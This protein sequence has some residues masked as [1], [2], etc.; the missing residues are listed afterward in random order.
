MASSGVRL[1]RGRVWSRRSQSNGRLGVGFVESGGEFHLE[2]C[3]DRLLRTGIA[4]QGLAGDPGGDLQRTS[5]LSQRHFFHIPVAETFEKALHGGVEFLG[6]SPFLLAIFGGASS[7]IRG[8]FRA[9]GGLGFGL[10]LEEAGVKGLNSVAPMEPAGPLLEGI[11]LLGELVGNGLKGAG[12][13]E[14]KE[15]HEGAEGARSFTGEQGKHRLR[16]RRKRGRLRGDIGDQ[17]GSGFGFDRMRVRVFW[18]YGKL[19]HIILIQ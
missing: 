19:Y 6:H 10:L 17:R 16:V 4:A 14:A 15:S 3:Q 13:A 1:K 5:N 11:G 2:R 9:Q 8:L 7:P 12:V 18:G